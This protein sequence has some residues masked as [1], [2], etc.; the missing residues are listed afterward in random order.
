ML[1]G[2]RRVSF[3]IHEMIGFFSAAAVVQI[4][5]NSLTFCPPCFLALVVNLSH[6]S[7][8]LPFCLPLRRKH[9]AASPC[10]PRLLTRLQRICLR[11]EIGRSRPSS[12]ARCARRLQENLSRLA[13]LVSLHLLRIGAQVAAFDRQNIC[14]LFR[15]PA[16]MLLLRACGCLRRFCFSQ[17]LRSRL[18]ACCAAQPAEQFLPV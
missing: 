13:I 18:L 5:V 2:C 9:V 17:S 14:S 6:L 1:S 4:F 3:E 8:L 7:Q 15:L 11:I 12:L 10:V 16:Q